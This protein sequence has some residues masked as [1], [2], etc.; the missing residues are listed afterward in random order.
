MRHLFPLIAIAFVTACGGNAEQT[1]SDSETE[2]SPAQMDTDPVEADDPAPVMNAELWV[3]D[4]RVKDKVTEKTVAH[5]EFR[6]NG[7]RLGGQYTLT[8][9][10]CQSAQPEYDSYCPF[11]GQGGSWFVVETNPNTLV[12]QAPDP[13][14]S[15]DD[16][17]VTLFSLDGKTITLSSI[18]A[19]AGRVA[20]DG[21]VTPAP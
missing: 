14:I 20:V 17:V 15:S 19:D 12:A 13:F 18:V 5:L 2:S 6:M 10:F 1:I 11:A 16:F 8:R 21:E 3:G 7:N 9:D 4:W